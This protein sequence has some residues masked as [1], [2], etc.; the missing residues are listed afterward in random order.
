MQAVPDCMAMEMAL[1]AFQSRD[2]MQAGT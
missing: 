1:S 2:M